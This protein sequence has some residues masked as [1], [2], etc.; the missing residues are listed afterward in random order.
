MGT[1]VEFHV[2]MICPQT[3]HFATLLSLLGRR[4]Y[5]TAY[6]A[7]QCGQ[8]KLRPAEIGPVRGIA[9]STFKADIMHL[10]RDNLQGCCCALMTTGNGAPRSDVN[11]KGDLGSGRAGAAAGRVS[12]PRGLNGS[13]AGRLGVTVRFT[14]AG[15][16]SFRCALAMI[17][18]LCLGSTV[19]TRII[20]ATV[21]NPDAKARREDSRPDLS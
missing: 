1:S 3:T 15:V 16:T 5:V 7:P 19:R 21:I 9:A 2:A 12:G 8:K 6:R 18:A 13:L 4:E 20:F 14:V 17:F 10:P 11:T